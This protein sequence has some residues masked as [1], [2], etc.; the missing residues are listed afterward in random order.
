MKVFVSIPKGGKGG[1]FD[2]FMTKEAREYM[3]ERVEVKY[4]KYEGQVTKEQFTE[5]IK[6]CDAVITGWGHPQIS[7]DMIN[8]TALKLVVHTGGSV[9]SL[10]TPD[11]YENGIRV[12]SGN[13]MYAESVAEGV[14][15]YMLM[16]LRE[17]PDYVYRIRNGEWHRSDDYSRGLLDRTVGLIG[18]GAITRYLV[19]K[20]QVFN[21]KLKLY[22][23][24]PIDE[25]ILKECR[26]EQVPLE[27]ALKCDVVS[28]HSSMNERTR[29]MI[30]KEQFGLIKDG[31]LFLNTARG[32]IVVEEDMIEALKEKRFSAVLD[33]FYDEPLAQDSPLRTLENV[34][35]MPHM[36]GPTIDRRPVIVMRL[37]DNILLYSE[38]KEMP[39]EID[40]KSAARM[41][42]GG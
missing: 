42:V 41:T 22:S 39:L 36:A 15:A 4:S 13:Q 28:L 12:L 35:C 3:E 7:Y 31:A 18:F 24:Y 5:E 17:L 21:V 26:A 10:V 33:V 8:G 38:G 30:G 9:G 34:Y 16:G 19:K 20:L 23:S 29:G 14:I 11:V 32:R 6:D 1:V 37:I 27:E 2:T 40:G 25:K